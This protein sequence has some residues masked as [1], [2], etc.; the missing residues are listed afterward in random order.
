MSKKCEY[1]VI[2]TSNLSPSNI[3][4]ALNKAAD[5][6]YKIIKVQDYIIIMERE[7][8]WDGSRPA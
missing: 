8:E 2:A 6:G 4:K 3:E 5:Q 7:K 1:K